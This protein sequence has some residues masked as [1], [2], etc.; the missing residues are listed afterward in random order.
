MTAIGPAEFA[1][2]VEALGPFE[3]NPRIAL[4]LSG[5]GDSMALAYL[6]RR[7]V[8]QNHGQLI[9]ISIDHGLRPESYS[10]SEW[11]RNFFSTI[12]NIDLVVLPWLGDKPE[13]GIQEAARGARYALLAEYCRTSGI[14]HLFTAHHWQDQKETIAMR[15]LRESGEYGLAG[16]NA[17]R[18]YEGVRILRPLL[19][20]DKSRLQATLMQSYWPWLDDPSNAN[21]AFE[22][23]RLRQEEVKV[24]YAETHKLAVERDRL[25]RKAAHYLSHALTLQKGGYIE[26]SMQE[27]TSAEVQAFA[28]SRLA[29]ALS[30]ADYAPQAERVLDCLSLLQQSDKVRS[31]GNCLWKR[32]KKGWILA[33]E[34]ANC[35][36]IPV[37]CG[38]DLFWDKRYRCKVTAR[39][40]NLLL[41]PLGENGLQ[42][43]EKNELLQ[44]LPPMVRPALPTL[45]EGERLLS[46][47]VIQW[48]KG[49]E[50]EFLP[51]L[52]FTS[53]GFTLALDR[54]SII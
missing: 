44:A 3:D 40:K 11:L 4:A 24:E 27:K 17:I 23:A 46:S 51:S 52:P 19:H 31:L 10:E 49:L 34:A 5:G 1:R 32:E 38:A 37:E 2:C 8:Q 7:W 20:I 14:L 21:P 13:H 47:P 6:L 9:A 25:D 22:R 29:Q 12:S 53:S 54:T 48:G 30:G 42:K 33:R 45:W 28:F 41:G 43:I 39:G 16:M 35:P 36:Y 50:A 18:D 26:I 15:R